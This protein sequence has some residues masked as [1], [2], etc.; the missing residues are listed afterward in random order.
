MIDKLVEN[1]MRKRNKNDIKELFIYNF[2]SVKEKVYKEQEYDWSFFHPND[3]KRFINHRRLR[4][5][6]SKIKR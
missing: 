5:D 4:L 3:S 2:L 6:V 1:R